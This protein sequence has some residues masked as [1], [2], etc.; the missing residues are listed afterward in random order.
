M[1]AFQSMPVSHTSLRHIQG[2]IA[3]RYR[4]L[5]CTVQ[6]LHLNMAQVIATVIDHH[7][8]LP[9]SQLLQ[10]HEAHSADQKL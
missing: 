9:N 8:D 1:D 7:L 6:R 2:S 10:N 3:E 5:L 4:E